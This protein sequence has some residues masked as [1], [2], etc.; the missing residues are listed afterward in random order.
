[1]QHNYEACHADRLS[2]ILRKCGISMRRPCRHT[3]ARINHAVA[4]EQARKWFLT[5]SKTVYGNCAGW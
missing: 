4:T 2:F 3:Y 5:F 1:M